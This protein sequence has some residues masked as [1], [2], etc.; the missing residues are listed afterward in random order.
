MNM[1]RLNVAL[2]AIAA[3]LVVSAVASSA[4][5]AGTFKAESYPATITG[6]QTT[7]VVFSGVV[8][9]WSCKTVSMQGTLTE[10]SSSLN[11]APS[12]GECSWAGVAATTNM[13]GCTYNFTAGNT[14]EGSESKIEATMDIKCP[15]GKEVKL[16]LNGGTCTIFIPEQTALKSATFENTPAATPD[17]VDLTLALTGIKYKVVNGMLGCPNK[18]A[19]GTYTNGSIAGGETLTGD[20]KSGTAIAFSV[21]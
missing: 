4:A 2:L 10:A 12:Y 19:D 20:N 7:S 9:K 5:S 11:L 6:T 1:Q 13:E 14:I 15:A 18:P 8:G 21:S 17:D 16:V 3:A